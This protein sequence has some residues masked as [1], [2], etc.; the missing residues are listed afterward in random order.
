MT[1]PLPLLP[2][3]ICYGFEQILEMEPEYPIEID[4]IT[5]HSVTRPFVMTTRL[6][7]L[8][9]PIDYGFN[10]TTEVNSGCLAYLKQLKLY[11]RELILNSLPLYWAKWT[12]HN[13]SQNQLNK[14]TVVYRTCVLFTATH[15]RVDLC[16]CDV[17]V[18]TLSHS[19]L[20]LDPKQHQQETV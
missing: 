13:V 1:T 11:I 14:Y 7:L 9:Q 17:W 20:P 4:A 16:E 5:L 19:P 8:P 10:H 15:S 3:S 6:P 18:S 2:Q 12:T